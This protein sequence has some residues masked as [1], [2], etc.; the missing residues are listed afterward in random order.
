[1]VVGDYTIEVASRIPAEV[2]KYASQ[3]KERAIKLTFRIKDDGVLLAWGVQEQV[4]LP[5]T[6]ATAR[7]YSFHGGDFGCSTDSSVNCTAGRPEDAPWF[8]PNVTRGR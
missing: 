3:G 6:T 5:G 8:S 4:S 2:M 7:W 1:M